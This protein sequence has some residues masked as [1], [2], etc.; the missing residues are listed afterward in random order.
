M[1]A[2]AFIWTKTSLLFLLVFLISASSMAQSRNDWKSRIDKLVEKADSL[3]FKS[4]VV[5]RAEKLQKNQDPIQETWYYS[6]DNDKVVI[7]Q[8]RY[9]IRGTEHTEVY[10]MNNDNLI[11]AEKVEAPNL[12]VYID[13]VV[14]GELFF[15]DNQMLRQYVS[16]GQKKNGISHADAEFECFKRFQERYRTLQRNIEIVNATRRS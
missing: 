14:R 12:S 7:F 8:V 16:F 1:R 2:P 9:V 3:S 10:Y 13:E 4:Q 11:C 15:I 6:M 5:F